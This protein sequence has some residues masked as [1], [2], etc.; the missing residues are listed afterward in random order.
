MRI[1][2]VWNKA[3]L[4]WYSW[5]QVALYYKKLQN[6]VSYCKHKACIQENHDNCMRAYNLSYS[7][8]AN[9]YVTLLFITWV[10]DNKRH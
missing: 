5:S 7:S 10:Q 6:L 8:L 2:I 3:Y 4:A 9:P 1:Y